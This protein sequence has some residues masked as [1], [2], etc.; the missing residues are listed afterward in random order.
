[1]LVLLP[2]IFTTPLFYDLL[3]GVIFLCQHLWGFSG[4]EK[5]ADR[6]P[7]MNSLANTTSPWLGYNSHRQNRGFGS[8]HKLPISKIETDI[9]K[10]SFLMIPTG[11][12][13]FQ[14]YLDFFLI[15]VF[16]VDSPKPKTG[17]MRKP[18]LMLRKYSGCF[19]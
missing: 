16:V 13:I 9:R 4:R 19:G 12:A 1:M 2:H 10:K 15:R 11:L 8:C 7:G 6:K 3:C 5:N 14:E 17:D 18:G